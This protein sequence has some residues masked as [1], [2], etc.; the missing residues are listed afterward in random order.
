MTLT[1]EEKFV[2][3]I[4]SVLAA[5]STIAGYVKGNIYASHISSIDEPV[6][7]C[8]SIHILLV[9]PRFESPDSISI[10][11]QIDAW[12][13]FSNST[14]ADIAAMTQRIRSLLHRANLSDKTLSLVVGQCLCAMSGGL[15]Y[16]EDTDLQHF[17]TIINAEV[18]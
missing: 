15:M 13:K 16:E 14:Q 18:L 3:K 7:P 8:I 10:S 11:V 1:Q 17:P 6:F 4:Q 5:D 9:N 2:S 12:M